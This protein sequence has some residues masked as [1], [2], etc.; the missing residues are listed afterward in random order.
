[1]KTKPK[2]F[3]H[4]GTNKTGTTALQ[5]FFHANSSALA[6]RGLLYPQSGRGDIGA[7]E[8]L[9]SNLAASL[10]YGAKRR[11]LREQDAETLRNSL[12]NEI[13]ASQ[14]HTVVISS[15]SFVL[16]RDATRIVEFFRGM[17]TTIVVYLRR[18]DHWL[19]ALIAQ[20]IRLTPCP[21]WDYTFESFIAHQEKARGQYIGY[22]ELLEHWTKAFGK[23]K[24]IVRP[25]EE[26]QNRP[27]LIVDFLNAIGA[28]ECFEGM[29]IDNQFHNRSLSGRSLMLIDRI[30]RSRLP[31]NLRQYLAKIIA[32]E[33]RDFKTAFFFPSEIRKSVIQQ[34]ECDY[35]WIAREFL[36]RRAASLF[37]ESTPSES[38]RHEPLNP[39]S[40][41]FAVRALAEISY[42]NIR[43]VLSRHRK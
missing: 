36:G 14:C 5:S 20:A 31:A 3:L 13:V 7:G 33:S 11:K 34:N 37:F 18:H 25:F 41:F 28:D 23:D 35:N 30:N 16:K 10:G 1:M 21:P 15:E 12:F 29:T 6:S 38:D 39:P 43:H 19:E 42:D 9:H 32:E 8:M 24:I 26:Q 17:D 22:K 2:L 27:N 40:I 4:I